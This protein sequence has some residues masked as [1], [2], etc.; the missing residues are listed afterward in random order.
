MD[1]DG[2]VKLNYGEK[3]FGYG[4]KCSWENGSDNGDIKTLFVKE[5][6]S[7]SQKQL[8]RNNGNCF[9]DF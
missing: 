1:K 5:N 7:I 4:A 2:G 3:T 8:Q 6:D 9:M